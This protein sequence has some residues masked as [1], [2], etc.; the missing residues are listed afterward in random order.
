MN[1]LAM[2]I[3]M[4]LATQAVNA[5][6]IDFY[7]N[8][9]QGGK[10]IGTLPDNER[11][12]ID[13]TNWN[14]WDNDAITSLRLRWVTPGTIIRLYDSRHG[15][16]HDDWAEILVKKWSHE[17]PIRNLEQ[18]AY[19]TQ[20]ATFYET[21]DYAYSYHRNN[22]TFN[23]EVSHIEITP[24]KPHNP[25]LAAQLQLCMQDVYEFRK[26]RGQA[27]QFPSQG[28]RYAVRIPDFVVNEDGSFKAAMKMWHIKK[29][30]DD[31][32]IVK[33]T[34]DKDRNLLD[35]NTEMVAKN[36]SYSAVVKDIW[37]DMPKGA[38]KT[39]YGAIAKGASMTAA[40]LYEAGVERSN[41]RGGT[42]NF[43][44]AIEQKMNTIGHAIAD[45]GPITQ[46][47]QDAAKLEANIEKHRAE[48]N[49]S[50]KTGHDK[51]R[52]RENDNDRTQS[53]FV[54]TNRSGP[55]NYVASI[56]GRFDSTLSFKINGRTR[57]CKENSRKCTWKS[58]DST[59]SVNGCKKMR[60]KV[61]ET[62]TAYGYEGNMLGAA[63]IRK[64]N[65]N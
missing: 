15:R 65:A 35:S 57:T 34:F 49:A 43:P 8:K 40:R 42:E 3:V 12:S 4:V 58:N 63:S 51:R 23:S 48:M 38:E 55:Y 22:G 36:K 44:N 50:H 31:V 16:T 62:I 59:P 41:K 2:A 37:K 14:G 30:Q 56:N 26:K 17:I 29:S 46:S 54:R 39:K 11:V 7:E 20:N 5:G 24:A 45:C 9:A 13:L 32:A 1:K 64:C 19:R 61:G 28:H 10:R 25:P 27:H 60:K 21:D 6:H 18:H 52:A 33:M 53:P 47:E